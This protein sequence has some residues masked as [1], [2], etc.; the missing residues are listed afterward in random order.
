M[1]FYFKAIHP[2][3]A[4]TTLPIGGQMIIYF[5][6]YVKWQFKESPTAQN[7]S[8]NNGDKKGGKHNY[9]I[10]S[11]LVIIYQPELNVQ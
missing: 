5:G 3:L 2:L 10:K 11:H 7:K 1:F 9:V 4:T 6:V 8:G